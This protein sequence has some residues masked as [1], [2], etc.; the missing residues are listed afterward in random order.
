MNR[1]E[2]KNSLKMEGFSE[3]E[4]DMLMY[5]KEDYLKQYPNTLNYEKEL[6]EMIHLFQMF[7]DRKQHCV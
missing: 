1:Q 3:S 2:F 7:I 6:I 5:S 4:I